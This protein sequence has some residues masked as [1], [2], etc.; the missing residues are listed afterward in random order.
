MPSETLIAA[1]IELFKRGLRVGS[2]PLSAKGNE[3]VADFHH[4]QL[5]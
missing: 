5:C 4:L 1:D 3:V 2:E